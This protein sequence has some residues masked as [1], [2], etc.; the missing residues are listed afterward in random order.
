[1]INQNNVFQYQCHI[2]AGSSSITIDLLETTIID[3]TEC[4]SEVMSRFNMTLVLEHVILICLAL[5]MSC[6][7]LLRNHLG[8]R[9]VQMFLRWVIDLLPALI[10]THSGGAQS[11]ACSLCRF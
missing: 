1:M 2:E 11:A 4:S 8:S 3:L 6:P 9:L 5:A 10:G 7:L